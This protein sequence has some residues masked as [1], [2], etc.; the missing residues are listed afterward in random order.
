MDIS[1]SNVGC[2][3]KSLINLGQK[4]LSIYGDWTN[5]YKNSQVNVFTEE[6]T[7]KLIAKLGNSGICIFADRLTY[8]H[9]VRLAKH[10]RKLGYRVDETD[11]Y[12]NTNHRS[13]CKMWIWYYNI[14]PERDNNGLAK[15]TG[16]ETGPKKKPAANT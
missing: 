8:K 6:G 14:K 5:G 10:L 4:N 1:S 15:D 13:K 16:R 11:T 9:G 7:L 2:S 12:V 3:V